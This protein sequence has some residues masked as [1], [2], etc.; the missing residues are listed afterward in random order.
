MYLWLWG[1]RPGAH[2]HESGAHEVVA[3]FRDLLKL[4]TR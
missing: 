4:A 2:V 1:R 3:Q